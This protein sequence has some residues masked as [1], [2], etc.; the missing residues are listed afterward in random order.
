MCPYTYFNDASGVC[1]SCVSPCGNC[2]ALS[3][4]TS[5]LPAFFYYNS[6]CVTDSNCPS[7]TFA[8]NSTYTCVTCIAPC[9][10]CQYQ[11]GSTCLSCKSGYLYYPPNNTCLLVCPGGYFNNSGTC[12][13]CVAPCSTCTSVSFC[14]GCQVNYLNSAAGSCVASTSCPSG[15]YANGTTMICTTCPTG[16][17]GCVSDSNCTSCDST[18]YVFYNFKCLVSCPGGT[19]RVGVT[20]QNCS[21]TCLGCSGTDSTC[22][23]CLA[24]LVL[25]NSVCQAGCPEKYYNSSGVCTNCLTQCLTCSASSTCDSCPSGTY[26]TNGLCQTGCPAGT[27]QDTSTNQCTVCSSNCSSC[28]GSA[29]NCI[30]CPS[31][32]ILYNGGCLSTCPVNYYPV[33]G[34]CTTCGNCVTCTSSTTCS[35]CIPGYYMFNSICFATCPGS[36]IADPATMTCTSCDSTCLTCSGSTS[37]CTTCKGGN[38]LYNGVCFSTCPDGLVP[39]AQTNTCSKSILGGIIYFPCSITFLLWIFLVVFSRCNDNN[40][41]TVTCLAGGLAL[42]LWFSWVILIFSS[43]TSDASLKDSQKSMVFGVGVTGIV[44]S[45]LM[46]IVFVVWLK[47]KFGLDSGFLHWKERTE[48]NSYSF[49]IVSFFSILTMPFFRILYSRFFNRNNF[50]CFFLDGWE[51]LLGSNWFTGS[52]I[53][54][55]ALPLVFVCGYLIYLKQSYDQTLIFSIDTLIL[56]LVLILLLIID[57]ASKGEEFF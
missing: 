26:L 15:T 52:Y 55:S 47:K 35:Q 9:L 29:T 56:S 45:L 44:S 57:V 10:T 38:Y 24:P 43:Y 36:G 34:I 16:C 23:S 2:T 3:V 31:G 6:S 4:C 28:S 11:S 14:T 41:Q 22:T 49:R 5:C 8:D 18:I 37:N 46:G 25:Y 21:S 12:E 53:L 30:S 19:Y 32:T 20:C 7:G 40:T 39:D 54:F 27:Y 33:N 1:L 13:A 48:Y 17:T 42:I 51:L 50:S